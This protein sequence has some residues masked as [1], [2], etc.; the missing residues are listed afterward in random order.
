MR[1]KDV[2]LTLETYDDETMYQLK[3]AVDALERL[4]LR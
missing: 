1:H 2:H 4:D 3:N